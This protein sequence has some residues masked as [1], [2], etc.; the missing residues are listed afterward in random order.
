MVLAPSTFIV[1]EIVTSTEIVSSCE[2]FLEEYIGH[3]LGSN[4]HGEILFQQYLSGQF[5]E[6]GNY[7]IQAYLSSIQHINL[8]FYRLVTDSF[9]MTLSTLIHGL[10][11]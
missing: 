9:Q 8:A 10:S 3:K 6:R 11:K 2:Y 5:K 4:P 1:H 7:R